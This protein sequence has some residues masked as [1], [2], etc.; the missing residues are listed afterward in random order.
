MIRPGEPRPA[1][2]R[3]V[4][5]GD[6]DPL[7]RAAEAALIRALVDPAQAMRAGRMIIES[8]RRTGGVEAEVIALRT[9]ALACRELGD[10]E[11][12]EQHLRQALCVPGAPPERVAQVRLS[13]VTV[14]T[15]RG[16]PL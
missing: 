1:P 7:V 15:E 4:P 3:P 13:L 5:P 12:A 14:R 9:M 10:L 2:G 11:V 6:L 16:H 8:A